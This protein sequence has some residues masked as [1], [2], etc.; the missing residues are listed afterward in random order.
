MLS[1]DVDNLALMKDLNLGA[2][3]AD[4][5]GNTHLLD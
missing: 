4:D 5:V 2:M 3:T 1:T